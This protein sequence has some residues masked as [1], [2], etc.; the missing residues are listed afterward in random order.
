MRDR[1]L[2]HGSSPVQNATGE[3]KAELQQHLDDVTFS[4]Y[5]DPKRQ[6]ATAI[7]FNRVTCAQCHQ[8]SARDAVHMAFNDGLNKDITS[9]VEVTEFFFHDANEQL[10]AGMK[11]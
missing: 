6:N 1:R 3:Q 11:Y 9:P 2:S 8:T 5:R 10:K 4:F 7:N